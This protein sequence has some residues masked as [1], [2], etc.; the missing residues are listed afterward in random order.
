V[1]EMACGGN[2]WAAQKSSR[3]SG[4]IVIS[5]RTKRDEAQQI[6]EPHFVVAVSVHT[7]Y[8]YRYLSLTVIFYSDFIKI[9][10]R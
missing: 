2:Y 7:L 4:A 9:R 5:V 6:E 8:C 10:T 3:S 1:K